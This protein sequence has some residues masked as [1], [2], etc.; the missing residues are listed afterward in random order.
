MLAR[1][2]RKIESPPVWLLVFLALAAVQRAYLPLMPTG[3]VL[4]AIGLML[5]LAGFA[6]M[7]AAFAAF[8]R[9]KTTILPRETPRHLIRTG[10]YRYS[11]N[12]IYLADVA[13]LSGAVLRWDLGS[14]PLV[15]LYVAILTQRFILGEEAG[16]AAAFGADWRD[17]AAQV[18]RWL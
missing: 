14:L 10:I 6:V 18:R 5:I 13:I 15:A 12:P 2:S 8:A 7:T 9:S 11:R 1:L 16:C 4:D 3:G 17:Y